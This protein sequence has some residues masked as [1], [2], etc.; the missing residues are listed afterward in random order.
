MKKL[1]ITILLLLAPILVD[2]KA[3]PVSFGG[4]GTSTPPTVGQILYGNAKG[5]YDLIGLSSLIPSF[6]TDPIW[7]AASTSLTVSNFASPNISQWT[8]NVGYLTADPNWYVVGGKLTP[9]STISILASSDLEL[10]AGGILKLNNV[11]LV[12]GSTT[13]ANYFFGNSGNTTMTGGQNLSLGSNALTNNIS[14]EWN[15]SIGNNSLAAN[16]TGNYN[17]AIGK[18]A[19]TSNISGLN[20]LAFGD[21]ALYT[22]IVGNANIGIG[23]ASLFNN[24]SGSNSIGIGGEAGKNSLG[25]GNIFIGANTDI[26]DNV[27]TSPNAIAIGNNAKVGCANCMVLGGTST[28][29][30][31]VG[32]G[33]STPSS[34]LMVV[35]T[36]V[37]DCFATSTGGSCISGEGGGIDTETDPV[38]TT[39]KGLATSTFTSN[40]SVQD[41][42][43]LQTSDLIGFSPINVHSD[44]NVIGTVTATG[45]NSTQWNQTYANMGIGFS[46][47][48][49]DYWKIQN[50][51]WSTTSADVWGGTK[52]YLTSFTESDPI[53]SV[54]STTILRHGTTSDALTEGTN[55]KFYTQARVWVDIWASSTLATLLNKANTA[56]QTESDPVFMAASTSLAYQPIGS[57]LTTESD[58]IFMAASTSLDYVVTESDP[59]FSA[60]FA[61]GIASSTNWDTAWNW[62]NWATGIWASSSLATILNNAVTAY[63]WGNHALAGY[64]SA[65][66]WY[67]TTTDGLDEG[68]NNLYYT[69]A[70][71]K[72]YLDTLDKGYFF[73][74]TSADYWLTQQSIAS[75][76][77]FDQWLDSTSTA[78][79]SNL[80]ASDGIT[81]GGTKRTTWPTA[82]STTAFGS[83]GSVQYNVGGDA[84]GTDK[85]IWDTNNKLTIDGDILFGSTTAITYT[86]GIGRITTVGINY[87]AAY[88]YGP[89]DVTH[90]YYVYT[91]RT[92]NGTRVYS[93]YTSYS[94]QHGQATASSANGK[95]RVGMY[96][97][98]Y[99]SL[100]P[101]QATEGWRLLK[102]DGTRNFD[103]YVD[104]TLTTCSYLSPQ[105]YYDNDNDWTSGNTVT[106]ISYSYSD[107][108][109]GLTYNYLS[110]FVGIND[111][112]PDARLSVMNGI[113]ENNSSTTRAFYFENYFKSGGLYDDSALGNIYFSSFGYASSTDSDND[114]A[115]N[116]GTVGVGDKTGS[117]GVA[118]V[119]HNGG[120][121][122]I[123][124][125]D[126]AGGTALQALN[127]VAEAYAFVVQ[128]GWTLFSDKVFFASEVHINS[129]ASYA[130]HGL[131]YLTGGDHTEIGHC[132]SA[133]DSSGI[134]SCASN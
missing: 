78:T 33:T 84:S 39:W 41:G 81:L 47:T 72:T 4:T 102:K 35:G 124:F 80:V 83:E 127:T 103:Y 98:C 100:Y 122:G 131:C 77:P 121:G 31:N 130:G 112:T 62:G 51:F 73:A 6:E 40:V 126:N 15:T 24:I 82:S 132:T 68:S 107:G 67:A 91:Y 22:N 14:G 11:N 2:A 75:G 94:Y 79:F 88:A 115:K 55:N 125:S 13:L 16:T 49:A 1:I 52:G 48:S 25:N 7:S 106:P 63:G 128:T 113:V 61:S 50:N 93:P 104:V 116:V 38:Y 134:C 108:K 133:L 117:V 26:L 87:N 9:T 109:T 12:Y 95:Y 19:L 123:F 59:V 69:D 54:S 10:P 43:Y 5:L 23:S 57:Y 74:T 92:V 46:T 34:A 42:K 119:G 37:A 44:L 45:G 129:G 105:V 20:N 85:F 111:T 97:S 120:I 66:S 18:Q 28:D 60:S 53:Y 70:R 32:I 65:S 64:L 8:N 96:L 36:V 27:S 3:Y 118:G 29:A 30:V 110:K 89:D 99:D 71:T 58:P 76:N 86:Q 56:I 21:S 17:T 90:E 101:G 114:V